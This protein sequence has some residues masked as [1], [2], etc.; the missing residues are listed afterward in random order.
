[1][2]DLTTMRL[3]GYAIDMG[4][5][6]ESE[7]LQ[8]IVDAPASKTDAISAWLETDGSK[9][10]LVVI[11]ADKRP[12]QLHTHTLPCPACRLFVKGRKAT[13]DRYFHEQCSHFHVGACPEIE[14]E[15]YG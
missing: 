13:A 7:R 14:E 9:Q 6:S 5:E 4:F 10:G 1:M 8:M 12:W 2:N 3:N 11:L 15:P